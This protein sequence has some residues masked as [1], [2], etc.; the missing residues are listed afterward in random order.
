MWK[1]KQLIRYCHEGPKAEINGLW[2]P[3][4]PLEYPTL[5]ERVR[6]ALAVFTGKAE[7]FTWPEDLPASTPP[8]GG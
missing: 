2:V 7:A 8:A 3:A 5:R 6:R 4:K 1:L